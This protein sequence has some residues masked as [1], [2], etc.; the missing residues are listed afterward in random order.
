MTRDRDFKKVVRVRMAKTGESYAAARAQITKPAK[1]ERFEMGTGPDGA[2]RF[3]MYSKLQTPEKGWSGLAVPSEFLGLR[4]RVGLR[5]TMNGKAFWVSA[6]PMG[7][8]NHWVTVNKAMRSEMGLIG[9]EDVRVEF[10]IDDKRPPVA[11]PPDL[12]AALQQD[13]K[14]AAH[15]E[16]LAPSH[17]KEYVVYVSEAKR[18]ET[19]ARRVEQI[20]KRLTD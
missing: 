17:R 18:P 8:G 7:D 19:R 20:V 4:R 14:A 16:K 6:Q 11:V 15:F 1:G 3:R 2:A 5:G 9:D 13:R 10:V 12:A